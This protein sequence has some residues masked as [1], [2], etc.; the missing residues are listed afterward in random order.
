[1]GLQL[2]LLG[3]ALLIAMWI[4]HL[5][6]F[7]GATLFAWFG[8][9]VVAQNIVGSAFNS[10]IGDFTQ[11]WIYVFAIG[12]LGGVVQRAGGTQVSG[13]GGGNSNGS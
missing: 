7:G 6:L 5:A 9:M 1:V 12:V 10:H 8:F 2:G 3:A 13:F 11:G 4:A